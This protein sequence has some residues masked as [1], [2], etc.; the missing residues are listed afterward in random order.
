MTDPSS[1]R[2]I[3]CGCSVPQRVIDQRRIREREAITGGKFDGFICPNC[4]T[5]E[6]RR[7]AFKEGHIRH[8]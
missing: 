2:C 1:A 4:T 6:E 3:R 7:E 5:P 8:E